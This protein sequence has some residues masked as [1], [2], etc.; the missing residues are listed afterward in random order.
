VGRTESLDLLSR[1]LRAR[2]HPSCSLLWA[3]D[4]PHTPPAEIHIVSMRPRIALPLLLLTLTLCGLAQ[5]TRGT[6]PLGSFSGGHSDVVNEANLN[7]HF[8]S[9]VIHKAGRGMP[10]TYDLSYDSSVYYAFTDPNTGV[11]SWQPVTNWGWRG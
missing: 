3:N 5:V 11:T 2:R 10:F 6:P 8:T 9:P 1:N 4:P 7:V